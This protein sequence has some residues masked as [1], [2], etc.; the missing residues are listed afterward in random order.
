VGS[1]WVGGVGWGGGGGVLSE[2]RY[3]VLTAVADGEFRA[4][5]RVLD[6]RYSLPICFRCMAAPSER[7]DIFM[8]RVREGIL[9][10]VQVP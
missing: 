5:L 3:T 10:T 2:T 4:G 1:G 9:L 6:R 8:D 7:V